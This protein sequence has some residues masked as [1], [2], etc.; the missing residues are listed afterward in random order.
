MPAGYSSR[1]KVCNSQHRVKIERWAKEEGMSPR[2]ISSKLKEEFGEEISHKSI[3][4]HLNEHFDVKA[5]VREQYQKS[6]E[7]YQKAVEKRLSDIEMLD[8]TIADNFELSQATNAWLQ[9]LIEK[10]GK[11]PL[12]LVQLREKLQ[13]E[14][15]QAIKQKAELLGD[16]P[17]SRLADGVATWMELVQAVMT[18]ENE[19]DT[20]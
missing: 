11:I 16:D 17:M 7:Q 12:S 5:E 2:A 14:M 15:R 8:A 4:Q 10:Q 9:D 3:W 1:C 20:S 6:Q 13:S 19:Q 18:D